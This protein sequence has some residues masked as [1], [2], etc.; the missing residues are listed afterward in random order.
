VASA[1]LFCLTFGLTEGQRY[2][3][4]AWIW[5]LFGACAVLAAA[6]A[7]QQRVRQDREPLVPFVLFRD[8]NF[9][10]LNVVAVIVFA[11]VIGTFLP[12]TLYLQSVLGLS[13]VKAGL[14]IAPASTMAMIL[15]PL[16]GRLTDRGGGRHL[17]VAGL[18]L[19]GLGALAL[20]AVAGT[21][22]PPLAFVLPFAVL[23]SGMGL[24]F[25]PLTSAATDGVPPR[26]AGAASG[27][28]NTLRQTGSV[29]GS[30]AVGAVLQNRLAA[31]RPER[32]YPDAFVHALRPTLALPVVIALLGAALCLAV[33]GR[34][35]HAGGEVDAAAE[36][37]G[38]VP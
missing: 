16:A 8:R 5:T 3:W 25:A 12:M 6:F 28:N 23:G 15:S 34:R 17:L 20:A 11:A 38:S 35:E 14:V 22:R 1:A 9:A 37:A 2:G 30:A 32:D 26:L 21:D 36:P 19:F 7:A 29:L 31:G 27:I 13:A 4:N 10:V 33:K 24:V 18:T